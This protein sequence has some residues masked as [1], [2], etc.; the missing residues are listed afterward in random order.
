VLEGELHVWIGEEEHVL[1]AGDS[2]SFNSGIPHRIANLG[3]TRTVL[4]SAITP[5]SF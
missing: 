2:I 5:P 1:G 3:K 4:V